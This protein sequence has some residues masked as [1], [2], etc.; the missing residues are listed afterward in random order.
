M[1]RIRPCSY[2]NSRDA[3]AFKKCTVNV[4][5]QLNSLKVSSNYFV[6]A[7]GRVKKIK[8]NKVIIITFDSDPS[9]PLKK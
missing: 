9:P 7:K 8:K 2:P 1:F 3:I 5:T 6:M 4:T